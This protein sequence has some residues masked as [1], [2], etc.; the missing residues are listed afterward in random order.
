MREPRSLGPQPGAEGEV[1]A[2]SLVKWGWLLTPPIVTVQCLHS[3]SVPALGPPGPGVGRGGSRYQGH[4]GHPGPKWGWATFAPQNLSSRGPCCWPAGF[5]RHTAL[6]HRARSHAPP[7]G[8]VC[9]GSP[10][11]PPRGRSC[12]R[13][14]LPR[15]SRP[16]PGPRRGAPKPSAASGTSELQWPRARGFSPA[17]A[18]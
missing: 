18:D 10:S 11:F 15:R 12:C 14:S 7:P 8:P 9:R 5:G 4:G 6:N 16:P 3:V 1:T 2:L 13:G 17:R